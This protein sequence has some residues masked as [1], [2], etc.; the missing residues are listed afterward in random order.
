MDTG[1]WYDLD[2]KEWKFLEDMIFIG[3]DIYYE[4]V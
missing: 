4:L 3:V 1:G 2:T